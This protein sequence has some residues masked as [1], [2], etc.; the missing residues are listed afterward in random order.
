MKVFQPYSSDGDNEV[1]CPFIVQALN[2]EAAIKQ[3]NDF[4]NKYHDDETVYNFLC[5]KFMG[6]VAVVTD[7]KELKPNQQGVIILP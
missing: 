5:P 7:A 3:A 6:H 4:V 2:E 1:K